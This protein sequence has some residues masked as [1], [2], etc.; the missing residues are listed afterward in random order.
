MDLRILKYFLEVIDKGSLAKAADFLHT[1]APNISRQ[2]SDLEAELGTKLF[3][4]EGRRLEL[5][6][7]GLFLK[8]RA[9]EI[10]SLSER[11]EEEIKNRNQ[12]ISGDI[13]IGAAETH[14][15]YE[16]S[17]IIADIISEYPSITFQFRSGDSSLVSDGLDKGLF[18]FG[19]LTEPADVRKYSHIKLPIMEEWGILMHK[20]HPLATLP[21]IRPE[22]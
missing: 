15:M 5:T 2:I 1:T 19:I 9:K 6:E 22:T 13:F 18:D 17:K 3:K 16:I 4:K 8:G 10:L 12:N 20:D 14:A 7:D 21:S 11:T